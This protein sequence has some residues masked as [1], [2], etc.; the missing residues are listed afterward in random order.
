MSF[1]PTFRFYGDDGPARRD[2]AVDDAFWAALKREVIEELG[3]RQRLYP[4]RVAKGRMKN[5]E[6]D[7]Q[8]RVWRGVAQEFDRALLPPGGVGEATWTEQVHALRREISLRR[9]FYPQWVL[10]GRLDGAEADRKLRLL[11]QWHDILWHGSSLPEAAAARA[12]TRYRAKERHA[13]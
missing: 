7:K 3:N 5:A 8:L 12:A 10:A 1:D 2:D 6:A 4:G 13:A 11:E 9:H